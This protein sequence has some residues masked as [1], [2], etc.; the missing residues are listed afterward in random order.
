VKK[1]LLRLICLLVCFCGISG[2]GFAAVPDWSP[3]VPFVASPPYSV[4]VNGQL[5]AVNLGGAQRRHKF[6]GIE[7]LINPLTGK[8]DVA[9]ILA[10]APIFLKNGNGVYS[11]SSILAKGVSGRVEVA[12]SKTMLAYQA[13][14]LP[15]AGKCRTQI[16]SFATPS[17]RRVYWVLEFV[18]GDAKQETGW[19]FFPTGVHPVTVWQ[20]KAPDSNPSL[21]ISVDTSPQDM[22]SLSLIFARRGG[23]STKASRIAQVDGLRRFEP[24]TVI[25]EAYLDERDVGQGS[26][27]YWRTW[28]NGRLVV[29]S[30]G[31][32]LSALSTEP[33]QWF[34][35][36]YL[37]NDTQ[38]VSESW[39]SYWSQA[40]LLIAE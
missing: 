19:P 13:G 39:V 29:D 36:V 32:T 38:P 22:D 2:T 23:S 16:S 9:T 10:G 40:E 21:S 33:H 24:I 18:L 5:R 17:R 26:Q 11:D 34:M 27:G 30:F 28:V 31:P 20:L 7:S 12:Q 1:Y 25:M 37:Y 3:L 6:A 8:S 15:V 35:A 4:L 14:D